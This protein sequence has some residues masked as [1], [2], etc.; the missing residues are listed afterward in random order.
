MSHKSEISWKRVTPEGVNQQVFA[1]HFGRR[2]LFHVREKRF[3]VWQRVDDPPLEDWME[4]LDGV[5]RRITRRLMMPDDEERLLRTI[6][7]RFP[8]AQVH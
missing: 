2:W 7:E 5:R 1:R 8:D 4:L 6:R 3:D